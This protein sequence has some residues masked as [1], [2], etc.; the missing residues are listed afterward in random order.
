MW[1]GITLSE[2]SQS[3]MEIVSKGASV[4]VSFSFP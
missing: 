1:V 2:V 4:L 3:R